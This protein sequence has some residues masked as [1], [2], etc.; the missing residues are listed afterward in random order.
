M[1]LNE[2]IHGAY[3]AGRRV[4]KLAG[5]LAEVL[6]DGASVL[7][8]GCGDG[9]LDRLVAER[10]PD[11]SFR[12]IDVLVRDAPEIPVAPFNGSEIPFDDASVDVVLFVDVLHHT[13]DPMVLL[14]E[15]VRVTRRTVV[16][17]DHDRSGLLAAPTLRFMD[18]VG[19]ARFG[20]S[21]PYNY[22]PRRR[23]L[24]AFNA[25][26]LK[27]VVWKKRLGLY[28]QPADLVFGRSLHFLAELERT[29]PARP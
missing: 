22:W 9:Q 4:R 25:L 13:E 18:R 2:R 19:N 29:G 21:L 1:N 5:H 16:I 28:P 8:V 10:R 3:V 12:G 7:D 23:W 20:V 24:D 14:R 6:P 15:A 11:L 26:G 17:K 27:V